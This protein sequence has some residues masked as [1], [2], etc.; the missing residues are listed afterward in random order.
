M[1]KH[2]KKIERIVCWS[3]CVNPENCSGA[4]HGNITLLQ[5]CSCGAEQ[6]VEVNGFHKNRSGWL[7]SSDEGSYGMHA[8]GEN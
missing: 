1:H 5:T 7:T 8:P 4:A 3:D 6:R 2:K